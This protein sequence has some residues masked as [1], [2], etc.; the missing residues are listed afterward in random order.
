MDQLQC[1][2]EGSQIDG[3]MSFSRENEAEWVY[4]VTGADLPHLLLLWVMLQ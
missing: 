3:R 2:W 1:P 4:G